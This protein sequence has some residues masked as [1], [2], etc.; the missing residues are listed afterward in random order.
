VL[1]DSE[2]WP[3]DSFLADLDPALR[4]EVLRLG[5]E[6][7]YE[8]GHV[9]L[10]QGE[11]GRSVVILLEGFTKV[12][13]LSASGDELL[14]SLRARGDLLGEMGF[15]TGSPRSARVVVAAS[16][17]ARAISEP[18]FSAFLSQHPEQA[19]RLSAVVARRL[20]RANE[21]R[22]EYHS[23]TAEERVAAV[24]VDVA[25][26]IGSATDVGLCIGPELTQADLASL[27]VVS[28]RTLEQLLQ[29]FERERLVE[30]RRRYLIITGASR[31]RGIAGRTG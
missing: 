24:L 8:R 22:A 18:E 25:D 16:L 29:K 5:D 10:H 15:V 14:L 19:M 1:A 3:A 28:L 6:R 30:R 7:H 13:L 4:R 21:R 12:S 9:L 23:M 26:M 2:D 11:L 27:A 17:R 20:Q 31:L